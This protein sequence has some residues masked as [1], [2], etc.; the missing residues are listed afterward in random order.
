MTR[1]VDK[2]VRCVMNATTGYRRDVE[3]ANPLSV[4]EARA[5]REERWFQ[6]SEMGWL[7]AGP[8]ECVRTTACTC[9]KCLEV[10]S[11]GE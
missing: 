5:V 8:E 4:I 3:V 11:R 2:I 1:T 9:W 6:S 7:R 10:P